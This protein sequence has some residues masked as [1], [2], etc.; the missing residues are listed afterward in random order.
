MKRFFAFGVASFAL[1][2]AMLVVMVLAFPMD[3]VRRAMQVAAIVAFAVQLVAF[4][5]ARAMAKDNI[6][7]GWAVG[8]VLRFGAIAAFAL[9]APRL[10][11]P[12]GAT[13]LSMA[14][15][16]FVSTLIEPFFLKQ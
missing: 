15:F 9:V 8:I 10:S 7:A 3:A 11:L 4:T 2:G 13:L 1:I 6:V 14:S 12:L 16:L 5:I